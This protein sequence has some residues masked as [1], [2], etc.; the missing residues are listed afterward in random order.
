MIAIEKEYNM[1]VTKEGKK[2]IF[3]VEKPKNKKVIKREN[4]PVENNKDTI[5]EDN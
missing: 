4:P 2:T 5:Q 3:K 1:K